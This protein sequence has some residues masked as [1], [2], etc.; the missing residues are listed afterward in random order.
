MHHRIVLMGSV[1]N[2]TPGDQA[3]TTKRVASFH[4]EDTCPANVVDTE[5]DS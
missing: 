4:V 3:L 2:T 1:A 5:E